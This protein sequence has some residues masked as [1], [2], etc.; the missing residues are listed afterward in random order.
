MHIFLCVIRHTC[1]Q[2]SNSWPYVRGSSSPCTWTVSSAATKIRDSMAKWYLAPYVLYG[3]VF[4][5][6]IFCHNGKKITH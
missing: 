4:A 5:L 6:A 2:E 3:R 1:G